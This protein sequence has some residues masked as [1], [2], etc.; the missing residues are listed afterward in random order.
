MKLVLQQTL[1]LSLVLIGASL[2]GAHAKLR[3]LRS[4]EETREMVTTDR[5][6]EG[7]MVSTTSTTVQEQVKWCLRSGAHLLFA[8][9]SFPLTAYHDITDCRIVLSWVVNLFRSRSL[10]PLRR[11]TLVTVPDVLIA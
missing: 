8:S 10:Q 5:R 2:T 7:S 6:A 4:N 1:V 9:S 11:K 3:F